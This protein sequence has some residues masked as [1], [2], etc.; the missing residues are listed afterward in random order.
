MLD[1]YYSLSSWATAAH[2]MLSMQVLKAFSISPAGA[3]VDESD[4]GIKP[5]VKHKGVRWDAHLDIASACKLSLL[6]WLLCPEVVAW[7]G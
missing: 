7:G 6:A 1:A 3:H 5:S 2:G 4:F